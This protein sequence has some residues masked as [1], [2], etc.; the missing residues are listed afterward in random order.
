[1]DS[2][3]LM[4]Q[5]HRLEDDLDALIGPTPPRGDAPQRLE[6]IEELLEVLENPQDSFASIHVGG[7]SG[8]GSTATMIASILTAAG[9]RTGLHLSP[10]LQVLNERFQVNNRMVPTGELAAV[11]DVVKP[12][13]RQVGMVSPWGAPS[14]FEAQVAMAFYLF[15]RR[16]VDVAVVEVGLGGRLDATNVLR[17]R[18][19]VLTSIGL[20]HTEI[21]GDTIELIAQD[22]AGI[23]KPG[24]IVV[25]G[26]T[27]PSAIKV[28]TDRCRAQRVALW[29]VDR[30]FACQPDD[31]SATFR[32]SVPGKTYSG[33][34]LAMRGDFQCN[35]AAC[36]VTAAHAFTRGVAVADVR[37]GLRSTVLP[38]RME[39][40]QQRPIVVLDGAHNE[41]KMR[42]AAE[43]MNTGY[44]GRRRIVVLSVKSD[45]SY[46]D[47]M[48]H[49]LVGADLLIVTAFKVTGGRAPVS[50][51]VLAQGA[52][53]LFPGLAVRVEADP[54]QAVRMALAAAGPDDVVWVTG[55]LY[56][57]GEVRSLWH[58]AEELVQ[59]AE[60]GAAAQEAP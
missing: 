60:A 58:P 50:P 15:A 19:A 3:T 55:S 28:I 53:T 7:T 9:Y 59:Q 5:Y 40:V 20:D 24:Q 52:A 16:Q 56:L 18:V 45:K 29:Q 30:D 31:R 27:Q 22:K 17:P 11:W 43:A 39:E 12:A 34:S 41:D 21:L 32:V 54:L 8:K 6:R 37:A 4:A 46:L 33:L 57:V 42:A 38:G 26:V 1:M 13:V 36:A 2:A 35:N 47:I 44:A 49:A 14:Y 48:R 10:H 23:I 51:Q 25:S